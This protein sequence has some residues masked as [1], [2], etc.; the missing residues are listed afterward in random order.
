M[1]LK[2]KLTKSKAGASET[3]LKTLTGLG[4]W[5]FGQERLL[6]DTDSVRGMV[7]KVQ[8]L[9]TAEKVAGEYKP[10]ARRKPRKAIRREAARAKAE[11]GAK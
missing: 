11:Q 2:V 4:L 8:H 9:V 10:K 5:R 3:Q 7:F 1:A 6:P